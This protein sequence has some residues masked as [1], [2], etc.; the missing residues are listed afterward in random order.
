MRSDVQYV[1]AQ[2][3]WPLVAPTIIAGSM[4]AITA[5]RLGAHTPLGACALALALFPAVVWIAAV[6]RPAVRVSGSTV[7][8]V[9][10]PVLPARVIRLPETGTWS[11]DPTRSRLELPSAD[12]SIWKCTRR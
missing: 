8:V 3:L 10:V 1:L 9:R 6:L 4:G 5:L 2:P 7:T 12:G 11:Y